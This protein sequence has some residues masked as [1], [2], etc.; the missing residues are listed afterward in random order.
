MSN[1]ILNHIKKLQLNDVLENEWAKN[2]C[3]VGATFEI[4]PVCNLDCVHCYLSNDKKR[5]N[6][7]SYDKIIRI[8]DILWGN[9]ILFL[10]LTGGEV[11]TRIDF[12]DIYL[13]AK[14]KGFLITVFT[15]GTL[16][17]DDWAILFKDYP[18]FLIDLSIYGACKETYFKVTGNADAFNKFI[19]TL[20][21]LKRYDLRFAL[22][23]PLLTINSYELPDMHKINDK[24]CK[25]KLRFSFEIA[26]DRN[27][28]DLPLQYEVNELDALLQEINDGL[29]TKGLS[30][31]SINKNEWRIA[32]DKGEFVPSHLCMIGN[33]DF[34]VDYLGNIAACI[35]CP[36]KFNIFEYDFSYIWDQIGKYKKIEANNVY[37]CIKCDSLYYCKSCPQL[38]R[39]KYGN[40]QVVNTKDCIAAKLKKKYYADKVSIEELKNY[41]KRI[42]GG[43]Q[44][45]VH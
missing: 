39:R 30:E 41:Y 15:N 43:E 36:D 33:I 4:T 5:S 44:N 22:K 29:M 18:P 45:D 21:L 16:I 26:P 7:L 3:P 25:E 27:N 20:E 6:E 24:Y 17:N 11:F 13:Y 1:D 35:E 37:P 28:D 34:H 8:L 14:K 2:R 10:T 32:K 31:N 38:R 19:N 42:K 23:A 9:G 40:E 12:K